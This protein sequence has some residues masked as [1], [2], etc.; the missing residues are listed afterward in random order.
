MFIISVL[1]MLSLGF[2]NYLFASSASSLTSK[3]RSLNLRAMLRQDSKS[4]SE[5]NDVMFLQLCS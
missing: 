4:F 3:L 5:F 2:Q 1:A